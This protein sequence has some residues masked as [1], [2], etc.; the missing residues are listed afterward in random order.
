[1]YGQSRVTRRIGLVTAEIARLRRARI[2]SDAVSVVENKRRGGLPRAAAAESGGLYKY[3]CADRSY[4]DE[5]RF[6]Q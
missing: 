4:T 2:G 6:I 1:M 5:T 3:P